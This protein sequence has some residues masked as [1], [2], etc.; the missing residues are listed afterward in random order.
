MP[1]LL[2]LPAVALTLTT[3]IPLLWLTMA[4]SAQ[5]DVAAQTIPNTGHEI[6]PL[7]PQG[8]RFTFLNPGLADNPA[9]VAG[10]AVTS[11]SSPD[12]K[13]LLILTSGY[14]RVNFTSGPKAGSRDSADSNEYVFIYD[15]SHGSPAQKQVI[16]VPNTYSGIVFAPTG[17]AFYVSGGVDDNVHIYGLK[18]GIWSERAASPVALGHANGVGAGVRPPQPE[19]ASPK[20][21]PSWWLPTTTTIRSPYSPNRAAPGPGPLSSI[22]VR[23]RSTR[24]RPERPVANIRFG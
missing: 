15:T 21:A 8:A 17:T 3:S 16:Q 1:R 5:D 13:T 23:E 12:H 18:N 20:M 7:A 10:Q 22:F 9:Y 4:A 6:T 11:A 24:E 2:P 19:S 14:N